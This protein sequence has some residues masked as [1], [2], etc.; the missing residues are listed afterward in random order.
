MASTVEG[1]QVQE[2]TH[3]HLHSQYSLLDGAIRLKDLFP[4]LSELSMDAAALTDHGNMFGAVDFFKKAKGAGK[5]PIFGIETY[6][7]AD[8]KDRQNRRNYHLILLAKDMTGYK[9]LQYLSSMA[10]LEGFYYHPRIDKALL[11]EHSEGVIGLSACLGGEIAQTLLTHG[12]EQAKDMAK[13]YASLFA[14]G[15]FYLEIQPNGLADQ[16][17][18]NDEWRRMSRET[19]IPLVATGDCHYIHE[20]D[21]KAQE[22]LMAIQQGRTLSDEKRLRH[23]V[24]S[25]YLKSAA[26]FNQHFHDIP[27][28]LENTVRIARS[29]NVELKLGKPMLP[30]YRVPEGFDIPSYFRK[31]SQD[32]LDRRFSEFADLGKKVD[33][34]LYRQRLQRELDV[35]VQMDFPGYFLIVWDFINYAKEHGIPVGPGRGSGAGSL[36]AYSL[37][38]TDLDPIPYNLLFER[39]LNPERISMPDFDIDFC[40]NRRDGVIKYVSEKYGKTQVGQIITFGSLSA[41]SAI[42]DVG[43]VLGMP[44]SELNDLTKNLPAL[45]EGHPVTMDWALENEPRFK[46]IAA[47]KPEFQELIDIATALEGLHRNAGMHAAGIVIADSPLWDHVPCYRGQDGEIVTQFAKDEVEEAG[48]VKFDFLGLKTL[49]VIDIAVQMVQ[50]DR[51][52]FDLRRIPLDDASVYRMISEGDTTGV[53]QLESS[54]FKELLKKLK[55][56]CFE[57]IIAAG[58]LYRPGPLEGGMVDDFINR[59]HGRTKITY[60]HPTMEP[61]LRET[62]GVIVYQEQVMQIARALAGYS[63]GGADLLRRAMGKK[64]KEVMEKEKAKFLDGA[65]ATG[66]DPKIADEVFDL[67]AAFAGY[68]FNKSHSAAYGLV[69]YQTGY[70]KRHF[71][72]EFWAAILTCDKDDTDKV[73]RYVAEVRAGGGVVLPPDINQSELDFTVVKLQ[74]EPAPEA[75]TASKTTEKATEKAKTARPAKSS[76][77]TKASRSTDGI[78]RKGIR[79]GLSAIKG[80]GESAVQAILEARAEK[81]AF[82]SLFSLCETVDVRRINKKVLEALIKGGAVDGIVPTRA[83]AMAAIDMAVERAQKAQREKESGQTSLFSLLSG[84]GSSSPGGDGAA[85]PPPPYPQLPEWT[86]REKLAFEKESLGFYISGHPIER[87]APDLNKA[88]ALRIEQL[89]D[90][91]Q[92]LSPRERPEIQVGGVVS[93]FRERPLKSGNGRMAIFRLEDQSGSIEVV[94]FSKAYADFEG[95]LKS[96]EPLLVTA[97]LVS[98]SDRDGNPDGGEVAE[99]RKLH[100]RGAQPLSQLRREKTQRVIIDLSA[101][102][103][104]KPQIEGLQRALKQ[105]HG[106]VP[107]SLRI[108]QAGRWRVEGRLPQHLAILPSDECLQAIETLCGRSAIHLR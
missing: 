95:A 29:C 51:P 68:G 66:V 82:R 1:A 73:A 75:A 21:A 63:L 98:E 67:M 96:G 37:R 31:V 104:S 5:K 101:D 55:P 59:K 18:I 50:R 88:K 7:C 77:G 46:Q 27:E 53:F 19:G 44:F 34:D 58:A 99:Q 13:G 20:R 4:R 33:Q 11:K 10:F 8:H 23:E 52:D 83:A 25:Y 108:I 6:V 81:G 45:V 106:H 100:M 41:K 43:R 48:L 17:K 62:Y 105:F 86:P 94:C 28:A 103:T 91:A 2:F 47:E 90:P 35:I 76:K 12:Y 30:R 60:H 79:F 80:V 64:K 39:F 97:T 40:M 84:G 24:S 36:V 65:K 74:E 93:D 102:H 38:I 57:D 14:P 92:G 16:D 72:D 61:I 69:T 89:L 26:E 49:T 85:G 32:G 87:Y 9:N 42:K 71:P 3:L 15:D 107:V 78:V 54:G 70:L 56:D 22:V